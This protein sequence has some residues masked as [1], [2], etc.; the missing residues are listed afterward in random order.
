MESADQK[1]TLEYDQLE[2]KTMKTK[3]DRK[4]TLKQ[5]ARTWEKKDE[6]DGESYILR[7]IW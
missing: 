6:I 5:R 3:I 1:H 4:C 2:K 7:E